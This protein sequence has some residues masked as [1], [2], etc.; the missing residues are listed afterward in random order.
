MLYNSGSL[1]KKYSY[2]VAE[3]NVH[4]SKQFPTVI[5]TGFMLVNEYQLGTQKRNEHICKNHPFQTVATQ[6]PAETVILLQFLQIIP[7]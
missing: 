3:C 2:I 4:N 5:S 7:H 1:R 6:R